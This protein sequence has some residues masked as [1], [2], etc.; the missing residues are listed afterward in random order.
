MD[1]DEVRELAAVLKT[2]GIFE[3]DIP[4]GS[5]TEKTEART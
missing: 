1:A 3:E 5:P 4:R 2:A